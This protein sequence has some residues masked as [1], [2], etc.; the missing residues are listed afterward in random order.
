RD[1]VADV[2]LGLTALGFA[3]G[4]FAVLLSRNR[5][6]PLIAD[7]GVQHARGAPVVLYN[8]LAPDQAAYIANHCEASVAF[9]ENR[10]CLRTLE[11]V[12]GDLPHLRTVIL[13]DDSP[14]DDDAGWTMTFDGLRAKGREVLRRDPSAFDAL[15]RQVGPRDLAALVYTSGTTGQPKGVMLSQR[16]ILWE[17]AAAN[18]LVAP[19]TAERTI[20][21]LPLAHVT[22][23]WLD[24]W[25]H[26][27]NGGTVHCCPDPLQLFVY[28]MDVHPTTL[29]GVPRV[30]EKLYAA[31]QAGITA[32]PDAARREGVLKAIEVRRQVIRLQQQGSSVAPEL[33][34]A[35]ERAAAVGQ[36]L[37]ARVGLDQCDRAATG[38]APIDPGIIEFFQAIGLQMIEAWGMTEL[39]CAATGNPSEAI[40]NGTIGVAAPGVEMRLAD[41]GE[42]LVRAGLMMEGYYK[43]PEATA[44]TIDA[45]GWLHTGDVG[46]VDR[47]G[48]FRIIGRKKELIITAGGKNIAPV[49]IEFLLEQHPLIGQACAIGDR[50][51][52]VNALLVLDSE[53]APA[54]AREHGI[55]STS[56]VDLA[57]EPKVLE[58]VQRAVDDANTHLARVEQV[59]RFRVLPAEWTAR[60]GELTPTLKK[61]RNVI[62]ERNADVIE[63][64]YATPAAEPASPRPDHPTSS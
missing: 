54:W 48:Y 17:A 53:R 18:S 34:A 35:A 57:R 64:L 62:L 2:A 44:A 51:P 56:L 39:T 60:T 31:L 28:A 4:Q 32:E 5:P 19:R 41:D 15:W 24:L 14:S 47:D 52:Y 23:R 63:A 40:R 3:P 7:L 43:D 29:V 61:R 26:I 46:E 10:Q 13:F 30:W 36:L 22:G 38:A 21:Y 55:A 9:V 37:R 25:S 49:A 11:V 1:A 16:N 12:R 27:I 42:I 58:E 6:E 20:S 45:D 8:T 59:K 33:A 50:R